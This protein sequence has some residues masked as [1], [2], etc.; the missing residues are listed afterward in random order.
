MAWNPVD[1]KPSLTYLWIVEFTALE[2]TCAEA[3]N[4]IYFVLR[5]ALNSFGKESFF[6][7]FSAMFGQGWGVWCL[8]LSRV[9]EFCWIDTRGWAF[10][11][12]RV[13][14]CVCPGGMV[15][16]MTDSRIIVLAEKLRRGLSKIQENSVVNS[17]GF[18]L[19]LCTTYSKQNFFHWYRNGIVNVT[20][21]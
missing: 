20:L 4:L 1:R 13:I 3:M 12:S 11:H 15:T 2:L 7:K 21:V 18:V 16:D 17:Q 9:L 6:V 14:S 19:E 8:S 10:C 5:S